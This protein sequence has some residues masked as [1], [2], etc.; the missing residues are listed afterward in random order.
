[1]SRDWKHVSQNE[2]RVGLARDPMQ[3]RKAPWRFWNR[4]CLTKAKACCMV[5]DAWRLWFSFLFNACKPGG[6][7]WCVLF[8]FSMF[9][10]REEDFGVFS[11]FFFFMNREQRE[12]KLSLSLFLSCTVAEEYRANNVLEKRETK[13]ERRLEG[14]GR[15]FLYLINCVWIQRWRGL[16]IGKVTLQ[17]WNPN[18]KPNSSEVGIHPRYIYYNTPPWTTTIQR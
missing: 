1:M 17:E 2:R 9:A 15:V 18:S 11:L 16:F 4:S 13:R 6:R 12:N 10:N 5:P 7:L 3:E 8:F 14:E